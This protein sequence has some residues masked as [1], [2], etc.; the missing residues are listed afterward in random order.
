[1]KKKILFMLKNMNVGGTEKALLNMINEI[2][3]EK[4]EITILMLEKY[5]DFLDYIPENV[6]V[7]YLSEYKKIKDLLSNPPR[8]IALNLLTEGKLVKSFSIMLLHILT[9]ILKNRSL[10]YRYVL[11]QYN[12][13][14]GEYDIAVAYQGPM[15]FISYFVLHKVKAKK[16]IQWIHFDITKIG[17]NLKYASKIYQKFDKIFVVS[18]EARSKLIDMIPDLSMKTDVL[19]NITSPL[20]IK[21]QAMEGIGFTDELD[22]LRILTVGRLSAEKGHDLIFSVLKRII[23]EGYKVRWYCIGE[24]NLKEYYE[25]LI[26]EHN[27]VNHLILLGSD[28]NPYPYMD[29]CD[30]YVQPS[31]H[32]GFCIT[33]SEAK[34]FRKPIITTNFTGANEQISDQVDG[35]IVKIS[36]DEIYAGLVELL[37]NTNLRKRFSDN[38]SYYSPN[39]KN[40][41]KKLL[42]MVI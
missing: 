4:Y 16:K 25:K 5:G 39:S 8:E 31:R 28:P 2:P 26:K 38:L 14:E 11:R 37:N 10:F 18:K 1:M 29:Q 35:L 27:L 7:K 12:S 13:L 32:E 42:D 21:K 34:C 36:Q 24:G 19:T 30:I 20:M 15:D 23:N 6:K 22:G 33:L 41:V 9:K 17:F 3:N 40:E